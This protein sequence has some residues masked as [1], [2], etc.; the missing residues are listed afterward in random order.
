MFKNILNTSKSLIVAVLMLSCFSAYAKEDQWYQVEVL[1]FEHL[2]KAGLQESYPLNPGRPNLS[3]AR[4]LLDASKA[5][6]AGGEMQNYVLVSNDALKLNDAKD[7]IQK[8]GTF[9]VILHKGWKQKISDKGLSESLRLV[10][11]KSYSSKGSSAGDDM[12][13]NDT[14]GANADVK[15]SAYEVDG[16]IKVSKSRYLHVDTDLILTKPMRVLSTATGVQ[17]SLNAGSSATFANVSNR[18]AWQQEA[19][20]RLQSFRL[21]QSIKMKSS[22]VQYIDHPMYGMLVTIKP[23]KQK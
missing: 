23:E 9:R 15:K 6:S 22:D 1:V 7:K 3:A 2:D 8:Q 21:K 16:T 18:S 19:N 5:Q 10:G 12:Q 20:A 17:G 4:S 11:G 13:Q 14:L